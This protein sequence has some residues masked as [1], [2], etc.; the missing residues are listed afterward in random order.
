M[1]STKPAKSC[2]FLATVMSLYAF[3]AFAYTNRYAGKM[4]DL[5]GEMREVREICTDDGEWC[6][7]AHAGSEKESRAIEYAE[8]QEVM[9]GPNGEG[10]FRNGSFPNR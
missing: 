10:D 1:K 3:N 6:A 9:A 7:R 4:P 2:L 5:D 8:Q